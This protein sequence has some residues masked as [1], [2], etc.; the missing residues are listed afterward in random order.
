MGIQEVTSVGASAGCYESLL[1]FAA[2]GHVLLKTTAIAKQNG[3]VVNIV[4][5]YEWA[6]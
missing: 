6:G 3:V 1:D 4:C 2:V 5:S